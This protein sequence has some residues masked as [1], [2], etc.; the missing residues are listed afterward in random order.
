VK[1][2]LVPIPVLPS[3]KKAC[4]ISSVKKPNYNGRF[5]GY[6]K[7]GVYSILDPFQA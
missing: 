4:C 7:F 2:Q 1:N 3:A 5:Y 6:G